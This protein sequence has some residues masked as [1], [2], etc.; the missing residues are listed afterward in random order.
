MPVA[1][2][3]A[4]LFRHVSAEKAALYR[5]MMDVFSTAKRQYRLQLRP[6]EAFETFGKI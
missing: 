2:S 3:S 5:C 1:D 4:D 6:D